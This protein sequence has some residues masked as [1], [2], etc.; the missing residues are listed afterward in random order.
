MLRAA[1]AFFCL[2]LI[3]LVFG[4]SGFA[5]LSIEIG[6]TLLFVFLIFALVTGVVGLVTGRTPKNLP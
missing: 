6:K 1:L 5:G 2:A 3:A 4:A